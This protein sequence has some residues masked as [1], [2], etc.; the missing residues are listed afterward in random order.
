MSQRYSRSLRKSGV[1]SFQISSG[2]GAGMGNRAPNGPHDFAEKTQSEEEGEK[3]RR[4]MGKRL[5]RLGELYDPAVTVSVHARRLP[6]GPTQPVG[7]GGGAPAAC[8]GRLRLKQLP[9]KWLKELARA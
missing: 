5:K 2:G 6:G 4:R 3:P 9:P 1:H 8:W 7:R